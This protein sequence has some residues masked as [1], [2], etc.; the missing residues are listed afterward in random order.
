VCSSDLAPS[1]LFL[2]LSALGALALFSRFRR[3]ARALVTLGVAGLVLFAVSPLPRAL[4]RALEDRF[5]L[6]T[7]E[8]RPIAGIIV[9]GGAVGSARGQVSF[10]DAAARM[11]TAVALARRHPKARLVFAGGSAQLIGPVTRTEADDA[12]L[13]F[14]EMGIAPERIVLENRSRNT[15]ENAT[16]TAKL[17]QI[18]P[19]ERWLLITSAYHMPRSMGVFRR[20]G[21]KVEAWPV[22][23]HSSGRW[24]DFVRPAYRFPWNLNL[25]DDV[26]KEWI[27]LI[28]YRWAGYTDTLLPAP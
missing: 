26:V 2:S 15:R 25:A 19:G 6:N 9:L 17:I 11:T 8:A 13:F 12:G 3:T 4:V 7:D 23:Y 18:R 1:V 21:L 27:G 22:D 28:A 10:T 24:T 14:A 20:A 5:P 16:E